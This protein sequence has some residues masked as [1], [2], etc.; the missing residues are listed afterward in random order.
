MLDAFVKQAIDVLVI[1]A[2]IRSAPVAADFH[3]LKIAKRSQMMADRGLAHRKQDRDI[4]HTELTL[5]ERPD[6]LD[7]GSIAQRLKSLSEA[8]EKFR[9]I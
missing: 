9:G 1:Q 8:N 7:T 2:V 3:E 4:A 6:D 5:R